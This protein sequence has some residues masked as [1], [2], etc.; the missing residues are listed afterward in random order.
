MVSKR[1][2]LKNEFGKRIFTYRG[3]TIETLKELSLEEFAKLVPSRERRKSTRGFTEIEKK[4]IKTVKDE[5]KSFIKTH[6]RDMIVIPAMVG[7][8]MGIY[9]GKEFV[10]VDIVEDMLG[11]RLGEFAMTR[12][13]T[14][15]S[16]V[17]QGAT[18][19][20]KFVP[21]K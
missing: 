14:K 6:A 3:K 5:T 2:E 9:N 11:H 16:G 15:H 19:S 20:S 13:S 18:K 10:S 1:T 8:K 21:L 4:L 7:K 17:G 12:K